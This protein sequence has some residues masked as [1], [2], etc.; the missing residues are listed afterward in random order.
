MILVWSTLKLNFSKLIDSP[1]RWMQLFIE[2]REML[3]VSASTHALT[4]KKAKE[5]KEDKSEEPA[6]KKKK[7]KK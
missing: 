3:V 1:R 6:E 2:F 7:K 5:P 4:A